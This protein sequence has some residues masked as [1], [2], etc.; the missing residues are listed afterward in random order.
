MKIL[1]SLEVSIQIIKKGGL[2]YAQI[3]DC[4]SLNLVFEEESLT[5]EGA[6]ASV[7]KFVSEYLMT[8]KF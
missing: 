2:H 7:T 8:P 4:E 1:S 5:I 3:F 6:V